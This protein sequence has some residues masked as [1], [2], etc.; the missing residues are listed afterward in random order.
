VAPPCDED[1]FHALLM[2]AAQR[3]HIYV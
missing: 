3:R 2:G 1:D